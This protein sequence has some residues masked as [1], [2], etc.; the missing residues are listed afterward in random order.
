MQSTAQYASK[1]H[2]LLLICLLL[3]NQTRK[4]TDTY[5]GWAT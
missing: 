1:P 3:F 5:R 2:A 4:T